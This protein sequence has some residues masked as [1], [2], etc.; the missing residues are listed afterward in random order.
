[1]VSAT[2]TSSVPVHVGAVLN[3]MHDNGLRVVNDFVDDPIVASARRVEA[4]EFPDQLLAESLWV[5]SNRPRQRAERRVTNFHREAVEVSKTFGRDSY[6]I[7]GAGSFPLRVGE[8]FHRAL[9][10]IVISRVRRKVRRPLKCRASL[11][12][13]QDHPG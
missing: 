13:N 7:H 12:V 10:Q 3:P 11:R 9:I 8:E 2:F 4:V 6:F 1:M 5:F